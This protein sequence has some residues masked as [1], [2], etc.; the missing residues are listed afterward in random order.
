MALQTPAEPLSNTSKNNTSIIT[1]LPYLYVHRSTLYKK[2]GTTYHL[3]QRGYANSKR[4][5]VN[6]FRS[7]RKG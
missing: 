6:R 3:V 2:K 1:S 4:L 7:G 5:N